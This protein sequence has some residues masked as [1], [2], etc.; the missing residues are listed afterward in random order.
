[1]SLQ[2]LQT[3]VRDEFDFLHE[4]NHKSFLQIYCNTLGIDVS[5]KMTLS[6]LMDMINHFQST[7]INKFAT[8]LQ[9]LRNEVKDV[10]HFF[11]IEI[12]IKV[13]R[14]SHYFGFFCYDIIYTRHED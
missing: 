11:C 13:S 12:K 6:L 7:Q 9:Y 14:S 5:Y 2:Y 1:M 10:V 3:Q 4:D 8:S